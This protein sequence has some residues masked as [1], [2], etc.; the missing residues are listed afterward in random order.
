MIKI[1]NFAMERW[2]SMVLIVL[3]LFLQVQGDLALPSYTSAIVDNGISS[4]GIEQ[5]VPE[6]MSAQTFADLK[7]FAEEETAALMDK[8]YREEDSVYTAA[9]SGLDADSLHT[10]ESG[11]LIPETILYFLTADGE[12][13]QQMR[14]SMAGTGQG[15]DA[16]NSADPSSALSLFRVLPAGTR[17]QILNRISAQMKNYPETVLESMGKRFVASEYESIGIDMNR[18]QMD[19]LLRTGLKMLGIAIA[20][21]LVS[22][23]IGFLSSRLAAF[24]A[25]DL[26]SRIFSRVMSFSNAEMNQ[27]STASLITRCTNDVQQVQMVLTMIFRIVLMAPIMGVGA[28]LKVMNSAASMTWIIVLAVITLMTLIL[29][30]L[31][32]AMP[33][34]RIMQQLVDR[35]NLVAREVLNGLQVIRAFGRESYEKKRFEEASGD[36][37]RTQLFTSRTMALMMPTMTFVMSGVSLLI[38]WVGAHSIDSGTLQVGEMMAFLTYAMQIIMSFLMISAISIILPRAAVAAERIQAVLDCKTQIFDP[39]IPQTLP[40]SDDERHAEISFRHVRFRY[41]GAEEDAL[42][43][44][45][46]TVPSGT[47]TA[48]IGGTGSG[49]STLVQL[50]PRLYDVTE[51]SVTVGGIDVRSLSMEQ[52]RSHIGFVPQKGTLFSGTI[53]SNIRY[54]APD[55][56]P[57]EVHSAARIAQAEDF[58]LEK[59][60]GYESEISQGGTNVSGGQKQRLAIARAIARRPDIYIFDDSFSALDFRTDAALRAA[61]AREVGDATVLIVAQRI[62]TILGAD[63]I[64]VLDDGQLAGKGTHQELMQSCEV[65]RQIAQSQ[66]SDEELKRYSAVPG[67]PSAAR[68][69]SSSSDT[70]S[71]AQA[72]SSRP[73]SQASKQKKQGKARKGR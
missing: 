47:T 65:Y 7:L 56:S 59:A 36:L 62:S 55:A 43:D 32:I 54:G 51:G 8:A 49:K 60:M 30:L 33:K 18:Y 58:I 21:T 67:T 34:F 35:L 26:R 29:I 15:A 48:I 72:Q 37:Y 2:G 3:L 17:Q 23:L 46:F 68:T 39:D 10:L 28:I 24:T 12:E 71:A 9:F 1:L 4:R 73:A 40:S 45:D 69:Q 11:L 53:D 52:L 13:A 42:K 50:I 5:P 61:L 19:Y 27:F 44:L 22:I 57:E 25:R 66:L 38:V 70:P 16:L 31:L 14:E 64:L 20:I 6:K 63:Q 41:P